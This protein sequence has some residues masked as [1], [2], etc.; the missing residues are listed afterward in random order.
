MR[1][2]EEYGILHSKQDQAFED[3][4]KLVSYVCQVPMATISFVASD[5]QWFKS[6]QGVAAE[7][8][9]R[10]IAF[11]AHTIMRTE[12]MIV[13]DAALDARFS[14]TEL[15]RRNDQIRFYAGFPLVSPEGLSLGSLCAMDRQPR[16][17]TTEQKEVM[18][19]LAR[20]VMALL[21]LRRVS[22]R[23]ASALENVRTL[24]GLLP[25]CAWCKRVR[26]DGGYWS[27]VEQYVSS[28]TEAEFSHGICPECFAKVKA[29]KQGPVAA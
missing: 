15:V 16:E 8:T 27:Q 1:A 10:D 12:P 24:A 5:Y 29:G 6:R 25:I 26:D 9:S 7:Q 11:C 3:I 18:V 17:L 21:E 4:T 23:L 2:L 20:Q 19:A 14:D 13:P 22:A 28:R